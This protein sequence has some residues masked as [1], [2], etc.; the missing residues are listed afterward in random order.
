ML[1]LNRLL[2]KSLDPESVSAAGGFSCRLPFINGEH[3]ESD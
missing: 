2:L 3:K 1:S